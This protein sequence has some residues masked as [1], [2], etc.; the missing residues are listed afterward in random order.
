MIFSS[1]LWIGSKDDYG[2]SSVSGIRWN[3]SDFTPGE[4]IVNDQ[5]IS[6]E[7][8]SAVGRNIEL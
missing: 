2:N 3:E 1:G 7:A 8:L 5:P 6:S 4:L